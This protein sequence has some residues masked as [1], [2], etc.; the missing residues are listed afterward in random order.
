MWAVSLISLK[1][2][3]FALPCSG[4]LRI[5]CYHHLCIDGYSAS[6]VS[7]RVAA[8]YAALV[9]GESVVEGAPGPY[10]QLLDEEQ[11]Y[12]QSS[13]YEQDRTYWLE[14]LADCPEVVTLSGQ[15]SSR[16]EAIR[17]T[18]GVARR[19]VI[20]AL[21][22]LGQP[23]KASLPQVLTAAVAL[24]QYRL[25]GHR[26]LIL[27]VTLTAR[28]GA[29]MRSVPGMV[30][31]VVPLRLSLEPQGT[32]GDVLTQV[33]RRMRE[34][35]RH[36]RYSSETLR[37]DLGLRPGE[38][39]F[40]G[41]LVNVSSFDF[42]LHFGGSGVEVRHVGQRWV[43]DFELLFQDRRDGADFIIDFAC[44]ASH[45][46]DASLAAHRNRLQFLLKTLGESSADLPLYQFSLL[47]QVE[48][49][50]VL[51]GFN[52]TSH[53][54]ASA[55][56]VELFESQVAR[57]VDAPAV[58]MGGQTVLYGE[59]NAQAN[60]LAHYL[61][62]LGVGPET[63]VGVC[64]ERSVALVVALLAILKAGGAYV[65]LDPSYPEAR[66]AY[67][68]DDASPAVLIATQEPGRHVPQGAKILELDTL[69]TQVT[70][71]QHPTHNPSASDRL[72]HV[73]LDHPAYVI[74]TSGSTGR[75]KGV[76]LPQS[77]LLNLLL[78]Q[79]SQ[80]PG[81][82]RVAQLA[83]VSF[84]V[85]VQ[86]LLSTLLGGKTL[87]IV[88]D[89]TRLAPERL[90]SVLAETAVSEVFAPNIVLDYL[91]QAVLDGSGRLPHLRHVYQA[92]EALTITPALE[93]FF[94]QHPECRLHN[95][96][97][98]SET[99][100]VT[101]FEL[102]SGWEDWPHRPS[103]GSA[104]WNTRMYV[105]DSGL[106]PLPVGVIGELYVS[107]L[108]L[109]RGY[110]GQE[111]LTSERF[112]ANPYGEPGSRMYRT[113]DLARWAPDGSLEF[114]GRADDQVKLR[115]FR[116]ELGEIE[117]VLMSQESVGQAAVV[118][119]DD[120]PS[121]Q[122]LVAYVAPLTDTSVGID[123]LQ[124]V[125]REQL[126]AYMIPSAVVVLEGL[127][128]TPNG[129]LD[130]RGLP[131]PSRQLGMYRGPRTPEEQAL[132]EMFAEVLGLERVGV[133]E[134]FFALGGHSLI[135]TRLVSRV[136]S[137]LGVEVPVRALFEAPSVSALACELNP[138]SAVRPALVS[139]PRGPR[140]P[141]SPAQF[142]LWFVHELEGARATYN[143]PLALRLEGELNVPALEQALGDVV[144]RH[145]SLRTVFGQNHGDP[146]QE[147]LPVDE[148]HLALP[149]I[150]VTDGALAEEL[151]QVATSP[152]NLK[153][154]LPLR[155]ELF[156]VSPD[157]HVLL[158]V[159]HHI[160]SD[161]WSLG[162][163]FRDLSQAYEA[164]LVGQAPEYRPLSV[165]YGDYTLWQRELLG[166]VSDPES[167]LSKQLQYWCETLA[168]LPEEI[169]LPTDRPRPSVSSYQGGRIGFEWDAE[170]HEGVRAL[171]QSSGATVF[172]VLQAGFVG[173]LS[174]LGCGEDIAIGTPIAGRPESELEDLV[175]FFVNTLVLRTDV[176]GDPSFEALVRR[177]REV[178]LEAYSHADVPFERVVEGL[179][180]ER[181][182]SRHPVFQVMFVLQNMPELDVSI[183][184][185]SVSEEGFESRVSKFDLTLSLQE[186]LGSGGEGF[187]LRGCL[188]YSTDLF[189][190]ETAKKLV[191]RFERLLGSAVSS[192]GMPLHGLEILSG[193]ER[194]AVLEGFNATSRP[195][196]QTTLVELFESQV[197][198]SPEAQAVV[199][200]ETTMSYG[201]LNAASNRLAHHLIELGV[202]PECLVGVCLERSVDLVV[203]LLA[204]LKAGGAYVPLDPSYP[205]ARLAHM[206]EDAAPSLII[207]TNGL[208]HRL[209]QRAQLLALNTVDRI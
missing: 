22:A 207:S 88:D 18:R 91:A 198:R 35:L 190:A 19:S 75:P 158:L 21:A 129:K 70:L 82:G 49:V 123:E 195:V 45:Y 89:E 101:S 104:I 200:G 4:R 2:L 143:I 84:D 58:M 134:D 23:Y 185:L 199:M 183:S 3:C 165:Q 27:G 48:R 149:V 72:G 65:P 131:A 30:S 204:I 156:R 31:N 163:L 137:V 59:L 160:V 69:Q 135:A 106:E 12:L 164:R 16:P 155:A 66:R 121:G 36:Q 173:L 98:P 13:R 77:T 38:P 117:S 148:A 205:K 181:S 7:Q 109:A 94:S 147:V 180:P 37:R 177:V 174:R 159:M 175:G 209:P 138:S 192:P 93:G 90:V 52:A 87:V 139:Q 95:H 34:A 79:A 119:R 203:S 157:T 178:A 99:H 63:L 8:H 97:G 132:C 136:R 60:R 92:G 154:E 146:Y 11:S 125:M 127:P 46:S 40:H 189:D 57:G 32:F 170:L 50:Q 73:L 115:G 116:I 107:G 24:Y 53:P 64:L 110:L 108:G 111:R 15:P 142:R 14:Q 171:A 68:L 9:A 1:G 43:E 179:N 17:Q 105:L 103:I 141:L 145:E 161:G 176:S 169:T 76:I 118:V 42:D 85:S 54:I 182:L 51:E 140:L 144:A 41:T 74:Y 201:E 206:I 186:R 96:Y 193:G 61:I 80:T 86:E 188:E 28:S 150:S 5:Y 196:P 33:S 47:S 166:E 162:P 83:S 167:L 55:N 100:V 102:V 208:G 39:G 71:A 56:L 202:G 152:L 130:R 114:I 62:A 197:V 128:M 168:G 172:M 67:I 191:W 78:W 153:D 126:P 29:R 25:S 124:R 187:G 151:S 120:G 6:L 113:G 133:D 194:R 26:D 112:V 122:E 44:H 20:D 10:C 81:L 184:G